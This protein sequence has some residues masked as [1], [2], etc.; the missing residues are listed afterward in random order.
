MFVSII[1]LNSLFGFLFA[2]MFE[3]N[4]V[5]MVSGILT[6]ALLV[7]LFSTTNVYERIMD[8]PILRRTVFVSYFINIFILPGHFFIGI[9]SVYIVQYCNEILFSLNGSN[10]QTKDFLLTFLITLV[11]AI[12]VTAMGAIVSALIYYIRKTVIACNSHFNR[13]ISDETN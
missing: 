13:K 12:L 5:A 11:M 10:L 1:T 7:F 2:L 4:P 6:F 8:N 3:F 9:F